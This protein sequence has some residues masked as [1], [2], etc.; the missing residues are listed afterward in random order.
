MTEFA[1][2][3]QAASL[4]SAAKVANRDLMEWHTQTQQSLVSVIDWFSSFDQGADLPKPPLLK[5][6]VQ[7][8]EAGLKVPAKNILDEQYQRLMAGFYVCMEKQKLPKTNGQALFQPF[9]ATYKPTL[10]A[11]VEDLAAWRLRCVEEWVMHFSQMDVK[12]LNEIRFACR[13]FSADFD[14]FKADR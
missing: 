8:M 7:K 13:S 2:M 6:V 12:K 11:G 4:Q 14:A 9:W 5:S 10:M 1:K 3:L